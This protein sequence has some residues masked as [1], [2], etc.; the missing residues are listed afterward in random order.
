MGKRFRPAVELAARRQTKHPD[1]G[2]G[3][4]IDRTS[5]YSAAQNPSVLQDMPEGQGVWEL[6]HRRL[7][8]LL[9]G[10]GVRV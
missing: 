9:Q 5:H 3:T 2:A 4:A 8:D 1:R 10:A 7:E 6:V